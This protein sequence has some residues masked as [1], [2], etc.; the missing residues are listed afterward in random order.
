MTEYTRLRIRQNE[1]RWRAAE[2]ARKARA[3]RPADYEPCFDGPIRKD[4]SMGLIVRPAWR[5]K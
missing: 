4:T 3:W 1:A 2:R 5:T